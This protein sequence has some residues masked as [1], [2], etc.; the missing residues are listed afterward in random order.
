MQG[1]N[2]GQQF[3]WQLLGMQRI[4]HKEWAVVLPCLSH[5]HPQGKPLVSTAPPL[6]RATLAFTEKQL[7][8]GLEPIEDGFGKHFAS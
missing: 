5:Q 2:D 6:P 4:Y 3:L 7:G 8:S 1:L